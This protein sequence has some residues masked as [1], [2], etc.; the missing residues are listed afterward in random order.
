MASVY[1][2]LPLVSSTV[3]GT[4]ATA[5]NP[6]IPSYQEIVNLTNV[7]QTFTAPANAK[8]AK[9]QAD[10]ANTVNI[11]VK[12]G[13]T[14]TTTSG[15]QFQ[16]GRSEDYSAVGDISVIAESAVANQ[17]IYVQFGV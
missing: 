5:E 11:R 8:W 17:K 12:I 10:D 1:I 14:A 15:V 13:G 7:A 2:Q 4:I 3:T 6:K 9:I 16:G